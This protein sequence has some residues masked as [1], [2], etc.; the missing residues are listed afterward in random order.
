M[1]KAGIHEC[2]SAESA[3]SI[4]NLK[5]LSTMTTLEETYWEVLTSEHYPFE[6]SE[7]NFTS[8]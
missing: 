4:E 8:S 3:T 1:G 6:F 5:A 7:Y 2:I